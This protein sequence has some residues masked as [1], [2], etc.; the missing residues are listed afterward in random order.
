M[1]APLTYTR[2][3]VSVYRLE[4]RQ[5][6]RFGRIGSGAIAVLQSPPRTRCAVRDEAR[7]SESQPH[8][9]PHRSG[10]RHLCVLIT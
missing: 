1:L 9:T 6:S 4:T 8:V 10:G 7:N 2:L 3:H 5:W